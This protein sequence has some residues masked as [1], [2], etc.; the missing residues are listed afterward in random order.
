MLNDKIEGGNSLK[1][2]LKKSK[3]THKI[4]NS[5]YKIE[6][7][8]THSNNKIKKKLKK[9]TN[10]SNEIRDNLNKILQNPLNHY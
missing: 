7:D 10:S 5:S 9:Q 2:I 1:K 4:Y 8:L 6:N 3:L